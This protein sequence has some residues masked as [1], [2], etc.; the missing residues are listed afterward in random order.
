MPLLT[1]EEAR[2]AKA[3]RKVATLPGV[4]AT[5]LNSILMNRFKLK[6]DEVES[7]IDSISADSPSATE[8]PARIYMGT[9][10]VRTSLDALVPDLDDTDYGDPLGKACEDSLA[11][12]SAL[13]R[14]GK[15]APD[16]FGEKWWIDFHQI[17][18][19]FHTLLGLYAKSASQDATMLTY[20]KHALATRISWAQ[21]ATDGDARFEVTPDAPV[22]VRE[23][24]QQHNW[25]VRNL[26]MPYGGRY[27]PFKVEFVESFD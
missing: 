16:F 18:L 3:K 12:H 20:A 2:T 5:S 1:A 11:V 15:K 4:A 25:D 27:N 19:N 8:D 10:L 13:A 21:V 24:V 9:C 14:A 17:S 23:A 7:F 26:L 6:A 22:K